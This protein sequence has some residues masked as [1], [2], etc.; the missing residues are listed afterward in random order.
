MKA[1]DFHDLIS[2]VTFLSAICHS[3][4]MSHGLLSPLKGEGYT[5]V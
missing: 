3:V 1:I 5:I 2:G 4:D